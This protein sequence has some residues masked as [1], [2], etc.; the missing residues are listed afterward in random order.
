MMDGFRER[1]LLKMAGDNKRICGHFYIHFVKF[2]S[3]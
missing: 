2:K 1:F 3:E